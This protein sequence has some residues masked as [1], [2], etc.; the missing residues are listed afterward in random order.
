[1][2]QFNTEK[3]FFSG[4][5]FF[6]TVKKHAELQKITGTYYF[7]SDFYKDPYYFPFL[8]KN[9][10]VIFT[11]KYGGKKLYHLFGILKK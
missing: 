5:F 6:T 3:T 9:Y 7:F 2:Q 8:M 1:M 4:L 10:H 11:C